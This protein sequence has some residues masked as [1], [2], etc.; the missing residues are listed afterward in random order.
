MNGFTDTVTI[1]LR[2][3]ESESL[4]NCYLLLQKKKKQLGYSCHFFYV[5]VYRLV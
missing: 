5:L 3:K 1:R 2:Q 4:P